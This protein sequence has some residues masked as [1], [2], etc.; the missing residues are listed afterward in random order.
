M[1]SYINRKTIYYILIILLIPA[2]SIAQ[3]LNSGGIKTNI[4]SVT[5]QSTK[6]EYILTNYDERTVD[7]NGIECVQY[8]IPGSIVLMEKGM[9]QLP[10][11]RRSIVIPDFAATNYS[12]VNAEY[13]LKE[14]L[15]VIPSK[16][17]FTRNIDPD[18]V[19]FEF[20]EFYTTNN[21]YPE[22]NILLDIPYI[23]R[24]LRGQTIQFNPMQY[25][26]AEGMLRICK[27]IVVEV[28]N[29][30][31]GQ[32]VNPFIRNNPLEAVDKDF[33]EVYKSLFINYGIGEFDYTPLEETGR[34]LIIYPTTFSS[35]ITPF[36]N[37]KVERGLTTLLAEYPTQTGT[38]S[39]A[40]K[41]YIQNLYNSPEGL[42]FIILV[43]EASQIPTIN[44]QYESAPSDPCYI[45]LAGSDAYPDAF[46]SRIS[47]TSAANLDYV[48]W[49]LI[50]YEKYP[51]TG[52]TLHGI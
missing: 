18:S 42:T 26:P 17:H 19:P 46:I 35:N 23:V 29:D 6:V 14:T 49:K 3:W 51:D 45:K 5:S 30:F 36:Y 25:N 38:G 31:G 37:W 39:T 11:D 24:D 1:K 50:R 44:G 15:P 43:G 21:W 28:F 12:I 20:N 10:S 41:N 34:L 2:S 8:Q 4:L 27:R 9:P 47:P 22:E 7:V 52:R 48:L 16:G 40:I 13:E 32:A 33:N